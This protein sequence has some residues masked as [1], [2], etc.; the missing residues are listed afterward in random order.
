MGH[1]DEVV[2]KTWSR[3]ILFTVLVELTYRCNLDCFFCY[4]DTN[5]RGKPLSKEQ[6]FR[7]FEDLRSLNVLNLTLSGGEPLAHPEFLALGK[8]G[9]ELGFLVRIK[10]NGHALGGKILRRIRDEI[11]PW[12]IE[13]SLH[14]ATSDVHDRQ[15]RVPGS[16]DRLI[17]NLD[18]MVTL[19]F[20][21]KAN[22]TLTAW[23]ENQVNEMYELAES[24]GIRLIIDPVVTPKDDG[25]K[26]VQTVS[27]SRAG[28]LNFY[29]LEA[30]RRAQRVSKEAESPKEPKY[31]IFSRPAEDDG[32]P[33]APAGK[34]CGAGSNALAIDPYGS[35]YP[36]VQ[37]RKAVGSLHER[38]I[39]EIWNGSSVL[40][41]VRVDNLQAKSVVDSFGPA[42]QL[43]GF[44]PGLAALQTGSATQ[45]YGAAELKMELQR[46]V[47]QERE[48]AKSSGTGTITLQEELSS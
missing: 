2:G 18:E 48:S 39:V 36:C 1:Y 5:L 34:N 43:M 7:L 46:E 30:E 24:R 41:D 33:D 38:S 23:N 44:C 42:G 20:R 3:N 31:S 25:D 14:G 12:E 16:F 22:S 26:A 37:W 4:N 19:G 11:D 15:T 21:V 17:S 45:V 27:A 47:I 13:I 32:M 6:Y 28:I 35:V 9:R 8:K 40:E 29:R 10:S